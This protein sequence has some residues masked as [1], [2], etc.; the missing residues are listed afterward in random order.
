M[1]GSDDLN[2]AILGA[3]RWGK[4]LISTVRRLE[5]FCL[6]AVASSNTDTRALVPDGCKVTADWRAAIEAPGVSA[7]LVATPPALHLEMTQHALHCGK[8]VFLE[9]PMTMDPTE[10]REILRLS[11]ETGIPVTVDHIHLFSDAFQALMAN[12]PEIGP[13]TKIRGE[14]GNRGPIRPDATVLWDWGPHDLAMILAVTGQ[15]PAQVSAQRLGQEHMEDGVGEH[16]RA[17]LG[18]GAS[19]LECSFEISNIRKDKRRYFCA[20]GEYGRLVYDD[21]SPDKL[22]VHIE[23]QAARPVKLA[24]RPA[25]DNALLAFRHTVQTSDGQNHMAGLE[26]GQAVVDILHTCSL[27]LPDISR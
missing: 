6:R 20:G 8:P 18:F 10:A 9:K 12:L 13:L 14:A 25:L 27:Q 21:L 26:L 22:V 17:V 15:R 24:G 23:G 5:G 3:G 19:P 16:I 1:A 4:A 7:V 11:A 2:V